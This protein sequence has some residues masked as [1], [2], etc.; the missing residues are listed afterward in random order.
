VGRNPGKLLQGSRTDQG[1]IA[2][3]REALT[4]GRAMQC[5]ILNYRKDGSHYWNDLEII[6]LRDA[7][8]TLTGFISLQEE[9]TLD[10]QRIAAL[11]RHAPG[12]LCQFHSMPGQPP[13]LHAFDDVQAQRIYGFTAEQLDRDFTPCLERIPPDERG[14]LL[15]AIE[16]SAKRLTAFLAEFSYSHPD[17]TVR[18]HLVRSSPEAKTDGSTLWHGYVDDITDQHHQRERLE[19]IEAQTPGMVYQFELAPDGSICI[20]WASPGALHLFGYD[21]AALRTDSNLVI[22]RIVAEDRPAVLGSIDASVQSL[23]PCQH[24][25]RYRHPNGELRWI[26]ANSIPHK[27]KDGHIRWHGFAHDITDRKRSEFELRLALQAAEQATASKSAFLATM[28][29]EIRTPMNGVLGMLDL[30]RTSRL[31]GEQHEQ[32]EIAYESAQG[33]MRILDDV[34]DIAKLEAGRMELD[35]KPFDLAACVHNCASLFRPRARE[36]GLDLRTIIA[37]GKWQ[38]S[39]DAGRVRQIL[40]NLISNAVKFTHAG[41]ISIDLATTPEG[42]RIQVS[43]TGIGIAPEVLPQLFAPFTQA[44]SSLSRRHGGTGLG[45]AISR[46]LAELMGGQITVQSQPD[47]GSVF[48]LCLP[49]MAHPDHAAPSLPTRPPSHANLRKLRVLVVE[50][51]L[52]NRIVARDMLGK[53][54][55][56]VELAPDGESALLRL[57]RDDL[58]VVFMDVQM[59]GI[60]GREATR[61]WRQREA[62]EQRSRLPIIALTAYAMPEDRTACLAS[63]MDSFLTKPVTMAAFRE[64]L[65]QIVPRAAEPK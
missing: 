15:A 52:I 45:L 3:L 43:D 48:A 30:L 39:G 29:H 64:V 14:V 6:P 41:T 51:E 31:D 16:L 28:S 21:P 9:I 18:R 65:S 27:L 58:D 20:P 56:A 12:L 2:R 36:T 62:S 55:C 34:L 53:L 8:G 63:G 46:Q 44:D 49:W 19:L 42:C 4:A 13:R 40:T 24:E 23:A 1:T 33:L 32:A 47:R 38:V 59:P 54:G 17:G 7:T 5:E 22:S 35:N 60:D 11:A 37:P 50:D 57:A 25:Y 61:L 10:R 26:A